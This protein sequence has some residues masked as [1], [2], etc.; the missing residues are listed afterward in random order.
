MTE[1][2]G[3]LLTL[4]ASAIPVIAEVGYISHGLIQTKPFKLMTD[5]PAKLYVAIAIVA[6]LCAL[7]TVIV[8]TLASSRPRLSAAP[9]IAAGVA[10]LLYIAIFFAFTAAIHPQTD[11]VTRSV[12]AGHGEVGEVVHPRSVSLAEAQDEYIHQLEIAA[13]VALVLAIAAGAVLRPI[14]RRMK[15]QDTGAPATQYIPAP[16]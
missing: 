11:S 14:V 8:V 3:R 9:L 4:V 7:V 12:A 5:P 10:T 15:P 16:Q 6:A 1:R 13:A 2:S